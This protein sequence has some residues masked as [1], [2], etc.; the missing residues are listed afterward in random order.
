[1]AHEKRSHPW[2]SV[3]LAPL[4]CLLAAPAGRAQTS[5]TPTFSGQA[6]VVQATVPPLAP[7]TVADTGPLPSSGG[8]QEASLLDV[9]KIALDPV[10]ALNGADVAHATTIARGI[11]SES[12]ASVADLSLTLAGNTI[13]ADFLM[14]SATAQCTSAGPTISGTSELANLVINNQSIVVSGATNQTIQL[15]LNAGYVVINQQSS[16]GSGQS[17]AI[18]VNALHVVVNN[19]TPGGAPLADV[20]ISH[21]HADITCPTAM[22]SPPPC[23]SADTDFVTGG[24]WIVPP[25]STN[26]ANFAVAGG[27]KNGSPWGHLLYL[28]HGNNQRVKGTSVISYGLYP[29]FG[30][31][32]RKTNGTADLSGPTNL[33]NQPY[34]ADVADNGEP[35]G[36]VDKFQLV[37]P[38]FTAGNTLAGGNIKLHKPFCQ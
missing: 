5:S 28:D 33:T 22:P 7:I 29:A 3:L 25:N 14:S 23:T 12:E 27:Y 30:A 36:G 20:I 11:T 21:V 26:K 34:E 37:L 32:G 15:P 10:G 35:G 9:P 24:G 16:S 1:M 4:V 31:N 38:S 18:D 8:A 6:F 19:T 2:H 13:S 17:G